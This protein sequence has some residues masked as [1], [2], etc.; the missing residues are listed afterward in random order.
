[1][2]SDDAPQ[3]AAPL[4]LP[5]E[6]IQ[7]NVVHSYRYPFATFLFARFSGAPAAARAWLGN[8][9]DQV[10]P[11]TPWT[12]ENKPATTLNLSFTHHGLAALGV[13]AASLNGFPNDYREGM[14]AQAADLGDTGNSAP[15]QWDFGGPQNPTI[16]C[17]LALHGQTAAAL[18]DRVT[19]VK[20]GFP[21]S[22][23]EVYTLSAAVLQPDPRREHFGFRDGFGQPSIEGSGV[24]AYPGQ[25]TA[26]AGG[27]W[28]DLKPGEFLL[29]HPDESGFPFPPPQPLALSRN[30]TFL[31]F[32]KLYQDVAAFRRFL[33]EQAQA[34]L[35]AD[36]A[37]NQEWLASRLVGRWRSGAPVDLSPDHDDPTLA[38]DW[39]RNT[40]FD[41]RDD[42][43]GKRCPVGAHIRRVN[44]RGSLTSVHVVQNHRIIRRGLPYGPQL[45]PADAL[46]DDGADRG[47]AFMALN[48]NIQ[49][50]FLF[51]Q[52]FWIND[53]EFAAN[54]G[55]TS[56]EQ[57]PLAGPQDRGGKLVVYKPDG[58]LAKMF[59]L[60]RFVRV[61]G[62]GYFFMPSLTGLRLLAA[63]VPG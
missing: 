18:A 33:K 17:L 1:M 20:A 50:Q 42:L 53:G 57:D 12:A 27:G 38:K 62:G 48:A 44:P 35:G 51:V 14:A 15:R 29:G 19:L 34:V 26:L 9:V 36:T 24:A 11:G 32:R 55:L 61:R 8:L 56:A 41:F 7:G 58:T 52:K 31:V 25:G 39:S 6:D 37:A 45:E 47:V 3:L 13:P 63:G 54:G 4:S 40:N 43:L 2:P 5:L 59:N 22:V 28:T 49:N 46:T 10:T 23:A 60:P 21:P 30:G 16:H